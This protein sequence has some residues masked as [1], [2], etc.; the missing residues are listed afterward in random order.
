MDAREPKDV[1]EEH[2]ADTDEMEEKDLEDVAGGML[3]VSLS[4][5]FPDISTT[6]TPAGPTPTP[7][8]NKGGK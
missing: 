1:P 8:P 3:R 2:E 7:Y 5:D 6:G 4:S